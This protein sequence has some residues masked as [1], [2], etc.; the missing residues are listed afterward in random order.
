[1]HAFSVSGWGGF[2]WELMVGILYLI[3]GGYLAFT[4]LGGVLTLTILLAALFLAE[5]VLEIMMAF[6]VRPHEGRVGMAPGQRHHRASRGR[7][8]CAG[9]SNLC[10]VGDRVTRWRKP[11]L[12]RV[13][14]CVPGADGDTRGPRS[15]DY[16]RL[17]LT[18]S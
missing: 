16:K 18:P 7:I 1:L 9:T 8:D 2:L 5:G 3:A 15:G 14:L 10:N 4:P 12:H 17:T 6:R 13:E 11:H